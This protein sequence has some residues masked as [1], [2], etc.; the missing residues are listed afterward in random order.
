[1]PGTGIVAAEEAWARSLSLPGVTIEAVPL[2]EANVTEAG[3]AAPTPI[4]A[5]LGLTALSRLQVIIDGPTQRAYLRLSLKPGWHYR[6]NRIGAVFVP[7][8][9]TS[10]ALIAHVFPRTP[11]ADAG[12]RDGDILLK[13]GAVALANWRSHPELL[14]FSKYWQ[15]PIGTTYDLTLARSGVTYS[16]K[17]TLRELLSP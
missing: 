17:V 3:V 10:D 16:T 2:R 12:I 1:M 11:A 15:E 14:P 9:Q 5:S 4:Y 7:E 8:G 13:I 6:S